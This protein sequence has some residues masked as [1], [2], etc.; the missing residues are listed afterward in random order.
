MFN[1][2]RT[3]FCNGLETEKAKEIAS[4]LQEAIDDKNHA[5]ATALFNQLKKYMRKR[6]NETYIT[7]VERINATLQRLELPENT[8]FITMSICCILIEFYFEMINGYDE[9]RESGFVGNAYKA[10]LPLLDS[11]ISEEMSNIFY[12]GIRCGI[13][14]Q[15]QTKENTALTYEIELVFEENGL[16]YLSNPNTVFERLKD[17]YADYWENIS[18]KTYSDEEGKK[19]ICKFK[20]ILQHIN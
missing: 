9:S 20:H 6:I 4:D 12:K 1:S 10:V 18:T 11:N 15:A 5:E 7:P 14:H 16:Y 3:W 17:L 8:T 19:L 2:N 13:L